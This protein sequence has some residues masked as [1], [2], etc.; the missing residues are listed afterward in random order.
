MS[1]GVLLDELAVSCE[2]LGSP[3]VG[4]QVGELLVEVGQWIVERCGYW[5][6]AR[7]VSEI[8]LGA[9]RPVDAALRQDFVATVALK[10]HLAL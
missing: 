9:H 3:C 4:P 10:V 6:F 8:L 1:K 2:A 7:L 5:Y